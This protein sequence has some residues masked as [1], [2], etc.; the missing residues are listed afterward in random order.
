M[1]ITK[2]QLV[3][4][5][6]ILLIVFT[7]GCSTS[8]TSTAF[9]SAASPTSTAIESPTN[10][11]SAFDRLLSTARPLCETAISSPVTSNPPEGPYLYLLN[12]DY[13]GD[14]WVIAGDLPL[15]AE[16]ALNIRGLV[17]IRQR[18]T[19]TG[20]YE[21][22]SAAY[23]LDWDVS[24]LSW[25]DGNV[26]GIEM[27][28]GDKPPSTNQGGG[29]VEGKRPIEALSKWLIPPFTLLPI[30]SDDKEITCLAF[31]PDG[32]MLA[33][34][35]EDR[36][37]Q[38]WDMITH[39]RVFTLG[40][41]QF[42]VNSVAFS[43][44]GTLLA[45]SSANGA[46]FLWDVTTGEMVDTMQT[47]KWSVMSLV[48]SPDGKILAVG[49][50][51]GGSTYHEVD[52][53]DVATRERLL[54]LSGHQAIVRSV[55]FSPDGNTLASAGGSRNENDNS[56]RLWD[57]STGHEI[58]TLWGHSAW[59]N[60]VAFSPDGKTLAST[61]GDMIVILWDTTL[62]R[63]LRTMNGHTDRI[64]EVAFL[65]DGRTLVT[66]SLDNAV[67]LWDGAIGQEIRTLTQGTD[68]KRLCLALT[69]DGKTLAVGNS[70]GTVEL[71]DI[72]AQE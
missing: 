63:E 13:T 59:V 62:G 32:E 33:T 9:N 58:L 53:W 7:S 61:G 28:S 69:P 46:V 60:S 64:S 3:I 38:I 15:E 40:T 1:N 4:I 31:S 19:K 45:S 50:Q 70:N 27:F 16:S 10:T 65:P 56:I 11:P 24:L 55:T 2:T 71:W 67:K 41:H 44:D 12:K 6:L 18:R 52:L 37:V 34:G 66:A 5:C 72:A 35:S 49:G 57:V 47:M 22:G 30:S 36:T 51:M 23:R 39:Q 54:T 43:P 21:D 68:I 17:C 8:K 29:N 25:P 42:G 26:I 20:T 48:F 14:G